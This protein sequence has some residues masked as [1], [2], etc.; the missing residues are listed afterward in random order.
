MLDDSTDS[1]RSNAAADSEHKW[2]RRLVGEWQYS[3][4]D[5]NGSASG[6]FRGLATFRLLGDIWLVGES[7]DASTKGD[8]AASLLT[9][10]YDPERRCYVGSWIGSVMKQQWVY[11]GWLDEAGR[12]LYLDTTGP[13]FEGG[14][15]PGR[16]QE[17]IELVNEDHWRLRGR[18]LGRDANWKDYVLT[19]YVRTGGGQ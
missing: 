3:T 9:L 13:S 11:E 15:G 4:C 2:L 14:T 16:Y 8:P 6:D 7:R 17:L 18:V 5:G 12:I 10:G 1:A 19:D